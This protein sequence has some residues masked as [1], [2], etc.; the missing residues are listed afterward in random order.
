MHSRIEFVTVPEGLRLIAKPF[1][2]ILDADSPIGFKQH[3]NGVCDAVMM[4]PDAANSLYTMTISSEGST[5]ALLHFTPKSCVHPQAVQFF[6]TNVH[7]LSGTHLS[8]DFKL[9]MYLLSEFNKTSA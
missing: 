9:D 5:V 1:S 4:H 7:K 2:L 3:A 8:V 6:N